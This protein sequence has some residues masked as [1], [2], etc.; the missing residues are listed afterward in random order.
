MTD[1]T[2]NA[3]GGRWAATIVALVPLL[4]LIVYLILGWTIGAW[5]WAWVV[6][7]AVPIVGIIVYGP[8]RK[9]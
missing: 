5:A 7:L 8:N 6:F 9:R 1:D 3:G 4:A 2:G